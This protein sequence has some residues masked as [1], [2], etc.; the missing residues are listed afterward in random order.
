MKLKA[1]HK[2]GNIYGQGLV[3]I[4]AFQIGE[5]LF[6]NGCS[7]ITWY[8]CRG[9]AGKYIAHIQAPEELKSKLLDSLREKLN[10][11]NEIDWSELTN[12]LEL[13][14]RI[15]PKGDLI[16]N[17]YQ[18]NHDQGEIE[19]F[20]DF[21]YITPLFIDK[22]RQ[23]IE[24]ENWTITFSEMVKDQ[25]YAHRDLIDYTTSGFYDV[26]YDNLIF[27]Q[28]ES[29]LDHETI[30]NYETLISSGKRPIVLIYNCEFENNNNYVLDG[31][32]KLKAYQNLKISPRILEVTQISLDD[33]GMEFSL[34]NF[35]SA[36][37]GKLFDW[38]LEHIFEKGLATSTELIQE[39]YNDVDNPF[40]KFIKNGYIEEFWPNGELK[41]KGHYDLHKANGVIVFFYE[42]GAKKSK[43][44][45]DNG[46]QI[47]ILKSWHPNG[48]LESEFLMDKDYLNGDYIGYHPDGKI[49]SKTTYKNGLNADGK[50]SVWYYR[51]GKIEYEAYYA[52]G[53]CIRS[54]HFNEQ[55]EITQE[56][57]TEKST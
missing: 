52:N 57:T 11:G 29:S 38:Q 44:Y 32:H 41:S 53:K 40:K 25:G 35:S 37:S 42:N 13:F 43:Q 45:Y 3:C 55:G 27:T 9:S 34:S 1:S 7:I 48:R 54:R 39:I 49:S 17:L 30:K 19:K 6:S 26:S 20:N 8:D 47:R 16:F 14:S 31:H 4:K 36:I 28:L 18:E 2:F 10:L 23:Q 51:N 56:F 15:F 12:D 24:L 46:R 21:E 5:Y 22:S 33:I 50:S